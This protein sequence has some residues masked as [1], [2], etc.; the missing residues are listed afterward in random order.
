MKTILALLLILATNYATADGLYTGAWS[1]H[2]HKDKWREVGW[3]LNQ[4]HNLIAYKKNKYLFGYYKNSFG[5]D[6][7]ML[8][9]EIYSSQYHDV[10][11]TLYAGV[12]Y[13]Y[14]FCALEEADFSHQKACLHAVPEIRYTK[15]KLQPAIL[16]MPCCLALSFRHE[17][18]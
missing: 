13:G 2:F 10:K 16:I 4:T 9:R 8:D 1:Y 3:P 6:T 5:D 18:D 7:I 11:F 12:S 17:F 14:R 15:Y